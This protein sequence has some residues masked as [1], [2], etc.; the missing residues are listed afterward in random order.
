MAVI[1]LGHLGAA[2]RHRDGRGRRLYYLPVPRIIVTIEC[3]TDGGWRC[4]VIAADRD[5]PGHVIITDADLARART[6]VATDPVGD[7]DGFA[8]LWQS[9]VS[10]HW[11]S[12]SVPT[13]A[14]VL[15]TSIRRPGSIVIDLDTYALHH[16]TNCV[17][18]RPSVLRL[19]LSRL[20]GAGMLT[21]DLHATSCAGTYTLTLP[22][23]P[24][25]DGRPVNAGNGGRS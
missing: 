5:Q 18:L 9:R 22:D 15:A 7:P 2:P 4:G 17:R 3:R 6:S 24:R 20:I 21:A 16:L 25:G 8:L 14:R 11:L 12:S 1:E 19:L 10:Q 13:L 23:S